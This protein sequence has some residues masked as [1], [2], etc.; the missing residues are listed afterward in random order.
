MLDGPHNFVP[1]PREKTLF[2]SP[3]RTAL[4]LQTP[5]T[6]PGKEPFSVKCSDGKAIITNQRVTPPFPTSPT[7]QLTFPLAHL[8]S[9][10]SHPSR[11][12]RIYH[13]PTTTSMLKPRILL[14]APPLPSRHPR[15]S[16]LLRPQCLGG[17][18]APRPQ[19]RDPAPGA[20]P[21]SE[22]DLQR[23]RR[24]RLLHDVR[25]H[26]GDAGAG[27]GYGEG[28]RETRQW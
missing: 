15:H 25:A 6:Y 7:T 19:R 11:R 17:Y 2:T 16:P 10:H 9:R 5:N 1:L 14:R 13:S 22:A 24:L 28:E 20:A 27:Y 8:P 3:P 18:P 23:G 12:S 21:V 26:Q 4:T